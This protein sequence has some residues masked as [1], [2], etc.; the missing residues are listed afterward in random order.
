[1]S[2]EAAASAST[3]ATETASDL[4][5]GVS[6]QDRS[7]IPG[8]RRRPGQ[9][10]SRRV[11]R[12]D[13]A[14]ARRAVWRGRHH[15]TIRRTCRPS[16][17]AIDPGLEGP[18]QATGRASSTPAAGKAGALY[19]GADD[20]RGVVCLVL[21]DMPDLPALIEAREQHL[22]DV[23]RAPVQVHGAEWPERIGEAPSCVLEP[24]AGRL[25]A[26]T[27]CEMP[28]ADLPHAI[29][30]LRHRVPARPACDP[31]CVEANLRQGAR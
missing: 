3:A 14:V 15:H 24:D 31:E 13:G 2:I 5:M 12:N 25:A 30:E 26:L 11:S 17:P 16:I 28:P 21:R 20:D 4:C 6:L 23:E 19:S 7:M 29:G 10:R 1:M 27:P 22:F 18:H 8:S 9:G